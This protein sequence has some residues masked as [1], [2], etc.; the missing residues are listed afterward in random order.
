M[1]SG[2]A[3]EGNGALTDQV[4]CF[5]V[6]LMS[7]N[8]VM[9]LLSTAAQGVA[10]VVFAAVL[11]AITHRR[12]IRV[13]QADL[14]IVG[15]FA[16]LSITHLV[17]FGSEVASSSAAF[18]IRLTVALLALRVTRE[19]HRHF[20]SIMYRLACI[21]LV[22]HLPVLF[23]VD[24][25]AM[26][27]Q[28]RIPLPPPNARAFHIGIHNFH[29]PENA[30]RNSGMFHE[31]G[32]FG[33]FLLLAIVF[34]AAHV[35]DRT[36]RRRLVVLIIAALT[37]LSTTA[38]IAL[39]LA[40][41][42]LVTARR[43]ATNRRG[44]YLRT[45]P[46]V[47][48][49]G[50][51]GWLAFY[52]LPFLGEKIEA[53]LEDVRAD[54]PWARIDRIGNL[55]YDLDYVSK[56]PL[57]GWSPRHTTRLSIDPDVLDTVAAQ[58]NGLSGFAVRYGLLG[59]LLF[60]A[61]AFASFHRMYGDKVLAG[62]AVGVVAIL[63]T[64]EQYLQQPVFMSLMFVPYVPPDTAALVRRRRAS[65]EGTRYMWRR[66]AFIPSRIAWVRRSRVSASLATPS[67]AATEQQ[68]PHDGPPQN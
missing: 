64:G 45:V 28:L 56:R 32:A 1:L 14:F 38:Y 60:A 36:S 31:P 12:R 18:L 11:L 42:I 19:F 68:Q 44:A 43:L 21:S 6:I 29:T 54:Q 13:R 37:T 2:P 46:A 67:V 55:L 50:V 52:N 22:F 47:A 65:S 8:P 34:G 62:L 61:G 10:F 63:L 4:I 58:G 23:R 7:G 15:A 39:A 53:K 41:I 25:P 3:S 24:L 17:T 40:L 57:A 5:L 9:D 30:L 66:P 27:G 20:T 33:G 26:L 48:L 16:T 35:V 51:I 59:L 49:V